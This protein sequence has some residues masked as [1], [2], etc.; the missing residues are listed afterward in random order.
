MLITGEILFPLL[1]AFGV[2]VCL[3]GTLAFPFLAFDEFVNNKQSTSDIVGVALCLFALDSL[4]L[5]VLA[6]LDI[7]RYSGTYG[8]YI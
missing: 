1:L 2:F 8:T 3:A 5:Y 7:V 4:V 6:L